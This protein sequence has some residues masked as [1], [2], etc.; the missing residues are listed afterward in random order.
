MFH[1]IIFFVCL[2]AILKISFV[3]NCVYNTGDLFLRV[4]VLPG[5]DDVSPCLDMICIFFLDVSFFSLTL[6]LS[7]L[8]ATFFS[9]KTLL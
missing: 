9:T 4:P 2:I 6:S 8:K 5:S 3:I 7:S 1:I